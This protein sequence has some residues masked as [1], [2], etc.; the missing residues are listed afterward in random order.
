[1]QI[2]SNVIPFR[3]FQTTR[4]AMIDGPLDPGILKQPFDMF[5]SIVGDMANMDERICDA[6]WPGEL[7]S[8]C[9]W[10]TEYCWRFA[11]VAKPPH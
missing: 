2:S 4:S 9:L 7:W 3:Q 1:M 6:G 10:I 5:Q 11:A 8:R